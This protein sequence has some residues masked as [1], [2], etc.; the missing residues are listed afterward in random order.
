[1]STNPIS[2]NA[3]L[4]ISVNG[5]P[6]A[7]KLGATVIDLLQDLGLSSGRV[8]IERNLAI[9]PRDKWLATHVEVGDCYEIV[10]FVGGG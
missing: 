4:T 8:A 9:L 2:A 6:R 10:H 5:E 1:M 3:T 7:V